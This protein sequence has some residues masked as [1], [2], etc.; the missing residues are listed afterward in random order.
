LGQK[1]EITS[2]VTIGDVAVFDTDRTLGGQ[3]GERFRSVDEASAGTTYPAALATT[4][5]SDDEDAKS[6]YVNSNVVSVERAGGWD[7]GSLEQ[8]GSLIS[9]FFLFYDE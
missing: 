1:I 4:L 8:T 7:A 2:S 3:D 9:N 6:V 5:L